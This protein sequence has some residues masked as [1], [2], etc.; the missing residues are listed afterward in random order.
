VLFLLLKCVLFFCKSLFGLFGEYSA[1][2][3]TAYVRLEIYQARKNATA[4][5]WAHYDILITDETEKRA[6][7]GCLLAKDIVAKRSM[8]VNPFF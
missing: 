4:H 1:C 5:P 7:L 6:Q 2:L 8:K 3:L